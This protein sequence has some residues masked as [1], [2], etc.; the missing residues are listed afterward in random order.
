MRR[1]LTARRGAVSHFNCRPNCFSDC[2]ANYHVHSDAQHDLDS[3]RRGNTHHYCNRH[4]HCQP[5]RNFKPDG[6]RDGTKNLGLS[7]SGWRLDRGR[8]HSVGG[9]RGRFRW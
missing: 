8:T 7:R 9:T 4:G 3:Y 1:F 5:F 2:N 6:E